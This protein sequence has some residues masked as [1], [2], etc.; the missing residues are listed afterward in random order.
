MPEVPLAVAS[1][2]GLDPSYGRLAMSV[3]VFDGLHRGH[4][5]LLS[6]LVRQARAWD[7]R[8]AVIT[9]DAHPDQILKGEAPPLLLDPADRLQLLGAAGI[10]LVVVEHFDDRLRTTP[11]DVF[12]RDIAGRVDL[13]GFVMTPDA[14]FGFERRGTPEAVASLGNELGYRVAVVSPLLVEGRS[15]SSSEVRRLVATGDLAGAAR[16]LGRPHGVVGT[17]LA[18]GRLEFPLPVALPP[19]GEYEVTLNSGSARLRVGPDG[20]AHIEPGGPAQPGRARV[21]F[22]PQTPEFAR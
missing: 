6:E 12:V 5:Q 16:L 1:I 9:F 22:R 2:A 19:A 17:A 11:Y 21:I 20:A 18:D 8:P 7:A 10:D 13:A 4:A 3:G 14:A 15:V